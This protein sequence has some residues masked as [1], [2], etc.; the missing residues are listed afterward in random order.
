MGSPY[1][2]RFEEPL[3]EQ[4]QSTLPVGMGTRTETFTSG[5]ASDSDPSV[6]DVLAIPFIVAVD[7]GTQTMTNVRAEA[8]DSDP[9]SV[10]LLAIPT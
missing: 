7:T 8:A 4:D 3:P 1:I 9:R 10:S 5:G 2:L 6:A